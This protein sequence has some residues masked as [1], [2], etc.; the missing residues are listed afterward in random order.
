MAQH[1]PLF[2]HDFLHHCMKFLNFSSPCSH[3]F[4]LCENVELS[5]I[6]GRVIWCFW[7][8]YKDWLTMVECGLWSTNDIGPYALRNNRNRFPCPCLRLFF[9][10][11]TCLSTVMKRLIKV[12]AFHAEIPFFVT[13]EFP[14]VSNIIF[15]VKNAI[16]TS[17][18]FEVKGEI[19]QLLGKICQLC[20]EFR[21]H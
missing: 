15:S 11:A 7:D 19:F 5:D 10:K 2:L 20:F 12:L 18:W 4:A 3:H 21:Q 17:H 14:V 8:T 1:S 13:W 16:E 9:G 6:V